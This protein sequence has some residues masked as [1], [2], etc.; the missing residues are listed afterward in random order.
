M[1]MATAIVMVST[2]MAVVMTKVM[3]KAMQQ[4][5]G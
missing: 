4:Q 1:A 3:V 5:Q 2:V